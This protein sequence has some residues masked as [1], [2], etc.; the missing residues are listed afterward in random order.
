MEAA[1]SPADLIVRLT[2]PPGGV[3]AIEENE[4]GCWV[5]AKG[6]VLTAIQ[7]NWPGAKRNPAWPTG[8]ITKV[9]ATAL[10]VHAHH[11][12]RAPQPDR[13]ADEAYPGEKEDQCADVAVV[14]DVTNK[15]GHVVADQAGVQQREE[16]HRHGEEPVRG[17]PRLVA[18][19]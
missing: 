3:S 9:P 4:N 5:I 10:G 1:K 16:N 13:G 12:P 18:D 2:G 14:H 7:P 8:S 11:P 6:E 17:L 15:A 19:T